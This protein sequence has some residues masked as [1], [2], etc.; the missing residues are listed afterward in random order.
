MVSKSFCSYQLPDFRLFKKVT[1]NYYARQ[2]YTD[3]HSGNSAALI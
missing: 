3:L 2:K 1:D